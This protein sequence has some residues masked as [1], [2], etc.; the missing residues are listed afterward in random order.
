M[1]KLK[2]IQCLECSVVLRLPVDTKICPNC[3]GSDMV[4]AKR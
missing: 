3:G 4:P 1:V 2:L